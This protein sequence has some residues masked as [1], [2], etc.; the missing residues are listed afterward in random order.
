MTVLSLSLSLALSRLT[1]LVVVMVAGIYIA[2][3]ACWVEWT[4]EE[5]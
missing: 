1:G 2:L 5:E 4:E 3:C